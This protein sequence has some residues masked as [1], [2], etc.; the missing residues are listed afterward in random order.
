M[1]R[2]AVDGYS[3]EQLRLW[4]LMLIGDHDGAL[5]AIDRLLSGL[6]DLGPG[7][8]KLIPIFDPL[9]GDPRFEALVSRAESLAQN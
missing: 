5:E 9:R 7:Q 8:L 2:D 4:T 3:M 6:S 1:D